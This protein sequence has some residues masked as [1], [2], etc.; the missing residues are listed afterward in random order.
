MVEHVASDI[1]ENK[2]GN[3]RRRTKSRIAPE[4]HDDE[5][6]A[7]SIETRHSQWTTWLAEIRSVAD[8]FPLIVQRVRTSPVWRTRTALVVTTVLAV[9]ALQYVV[10]ASAQ[11]F[12]PKSAADQ[13]AVALASPVS[14]PLAS[15][16]VSEKDEQIVHAWLHEQRVGRLGGDFWPPE[17]EGK[18]TRLF[19]VRGW[20]IVDIKRAG[21]QACF[22]VRIDSSTSVGFQVTKLWHVYVQWDRFAEGVDAQPLIV[23]VEEAIL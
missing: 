9:L 12:Q 13:A 17:M 8:Q 10:Q 21:D 11:L 20:E 2:N 23:K 16:P 1:P 14:A 19:A 4:I 18:R 5:C 15:V 7:E 3:L 6:A 22:T